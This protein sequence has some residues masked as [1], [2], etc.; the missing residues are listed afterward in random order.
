MPSRCSV[1]ARTSTST[2]RDR[3]PGSGRRSIAAASSSA[4]SRM[5]PARR[6]MTWP[7]SLKVAKLPRRATSPACSFTPAPSASVGPRL[8]ASGDWPNSA[9]LPA[10]VSATTP[11]AT[12]SAR[13]HWPSLAS[14]SRVGVSAACSGVR[15]PSARTGR[16]ARPSMISSSVGAGGRTSRQSASPRPGLVCSSMPVT[17]CRV[18]TTGGSPA[19]LSSI[20]TSRRSASCTMWSWI[21]R[22]DAKFSR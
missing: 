13:P 11:G 14:R 4:P 6:S 1:P 19:G 10:A 22:I 5:R 16:S 9:R 20:G 2:S 18:G 7:S 8:R 12:G 17:S 15:P 3:P 21:A